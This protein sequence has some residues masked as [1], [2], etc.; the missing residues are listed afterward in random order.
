MTA[1][2][3]E[4]F[5]PADAMTAI[6]DG[7]CIYVGFWGLYNEGDLYGNWIDL[8]KATTADEINQCIDFLR[9]KIGYAEDQRLSLI[10]I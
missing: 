9:N 1:A 5:S 8:E 7:P 2:M 4:A 10:H 3:I 6:G